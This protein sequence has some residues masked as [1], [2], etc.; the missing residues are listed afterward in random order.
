MP[1]YYETPELVGIG[2][3]GV[4]RDCFDCDYMT[5]YL[6]HGGNSA[7]CDGKTIP[8]TSL[9]ASTPGDDVRLFLHGNVR[10]AADETLEAFY[11]RE[12]LRVGGTKA[13][14]ELI[15]YIISN[16]VLRGEEAVRKDIRRLLGIY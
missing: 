3:S 13:I 1:T 14:N 4:H 7:Y 12:L 16:S 15:R 2:F 11:W 5:I 9:Y 8:M 10:P 6:V